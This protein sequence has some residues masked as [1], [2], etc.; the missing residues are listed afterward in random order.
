[1]KKSDNSQ[2]AGKPGRLAQ[3]MG[4]RIH[5]LRRQLGL[6]QADMAARLGRIK[7]TLLSRLENAQADSIAFDVLENLIELVEGAGRT[8]QWLLTGRPLAANAS[9]QA[10]LEALAELM[11]QEL[12]AKAG[13]AESA[14]SKPANSERVWRPIRLVEPGFQV[15]GVENL[16]RDWRGHYV[17][18]VGR[19]AAG[20]GIDTA[21]ADEHPPG[22]A[23]RYLIYHGAPPAAF[24]VEVVGDSMTPDYQPGDMIVV[25][26]AQPIREGVACVLYE[27][28]NLRIARLK[29]LRING[30]MA[31]LESLNAKYD[32]ANVPAS[33]VEAF[34]VVK[35]LP[36]VIQR[37]VC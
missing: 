6:S 27:A 4:G 17:P 14:P 23:E 3:A 5:D 24:A 2:D 30:K 11:G 18:I 13:L 16:P 20:Q 1:M 25:D 19:L 22:W 8:A 36:R 7:N 32:T 37:T 28:A 10:L 33:R 35:H 12:I 9:R 21:E 26:G 34:K 15:I 31:R 29:R